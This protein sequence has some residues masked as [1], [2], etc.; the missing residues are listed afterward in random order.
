M[1]YMKRGFCTRCNTIRNVK[2]TSSSKVITDP[3]GDRRVKQTRLYHCAFCKSFVHREN[4]NNRA[5][6]K[7]GDRFTPRA[8]T[9]WRTIPGDVQLKIIKTVWCTRCRRMT[10]ITYISA[11]IDT[12]MLILTGKCSR[13]GGDVARVIEND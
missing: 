3:D 8:K 13:C 10:G 7:T 5:I 11:R 2:K 6:I 9:I 4:G 1:D 12:G